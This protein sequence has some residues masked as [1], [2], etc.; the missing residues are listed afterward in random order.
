M[1]RKIIDYCVV[2]SEKSR[3]ET[4]GKGFPEKVKEKIK[5][6]WQPQGGVCYH[7]SGHYHGLSQAM[8]KYEGDS[9]E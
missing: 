7:N 8:V 1:E 6:G 2:V 5:E 3:N 4:G 9:D